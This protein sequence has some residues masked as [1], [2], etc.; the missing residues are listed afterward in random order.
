MTRTI[1]LRWHDFETPVRVTML[2]D[3]AP[4]LCQAI[5]SALPLTSIS[6][7]S[8]I[9][10]DNIGFPLREQATKKYCSLVR[11]PRAVSVFAFG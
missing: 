10:G 4:E 9:S 1:T 6:W 11:S 7:H 3:E 2:E 5:L 8:V